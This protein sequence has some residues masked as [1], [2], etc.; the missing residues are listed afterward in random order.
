[1]LNLEL[2]H[3]IMVALITLRVV[4]RRAASGVAMSWL[5]LVAALPFFGVVL[6]L[7]FGERRI[8][9]HRQ[10]NLQ[11]LREDFYGSPV[12]AATA[13][14]V[15]WASLPTE[16]E[17]LE[18]VANGVL[19]SRATTGCR[20]SLLTDA[21]EVTSKIASDIHGA[22]QSVCLGYYIW[23]PGGWVTEVVEALCD[24][25]GRGV[26]CRVLVDAVG[27]GDWMG[28]D[29]AKR[30][31]VAGVR[32]ES[33]LQVGPLRTL[34]A[35]IDMRLHRKIVLIDNQIAWTGS[36]NMAD[37]RLFKQ[38]RGVGQWV[39]AM[40]RV[41]GPVVASLGGVALADW[42]L[43]TDESAMSLFQEHALDSVQVEGESAMLAFPSGPGL[44]GDAL[45]QML[46]VVLY[47]ARQEL[48]L[49]T[50]YLIPDESL[51]RAIR[52]AA[53]RGV[54]VKL[55]VPENIDVVSARHASRSYY[56]QL[57]ELG[58]EVYLYQGGMLHTKSVT[59]DEQ[60]AV[61]GS[62]NLDM[63]SLWLNYEISLFVFDRAFC[64]DLR[65]LQ[66]DYIEHAHRIDP[67]EWANRSRW[68]RGLEDTVR[69][70][71]ALL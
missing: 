17:E 49:T 2:L 32:V 57:M 7:L 16:A 6:Y 70:A 58:V 55:I 14:P 51:L 59:V 40:V 54:T 15:D 53:A 39:D 36:Q 11:H 34:F 5:F 47:S 61:F 26:A 12:M 41:Q 68:R 33:A 25:A 30:L 50:P 24:A 62:A 4:S 37:P 45:L 35:R 19:G 28:S 43:E 46:L 18:H 23:H 10:R 64:K 27:S 22:S 44:S 29:E 65:D 38:D 3:F 56:D 60:L 71:S 1:M 13:V 67:A 66:A 48:V 20:Y 63:R 9:R 69:L 8:S 31:R 52:V 21:R 42:E